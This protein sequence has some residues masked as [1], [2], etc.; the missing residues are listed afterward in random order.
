M[1]EGDIVE[2]IFIHDAIASCEA[3]NRLYDAIDQLGQWR[4]ALTE[5]TNFAE[6]HKCPIYHE[7]YTKHSPQGRKMHTACC[8]R[9]IHARC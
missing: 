7:F 6:H 1:E 9:L 4:E 5:D 8:E 3:I 2:R